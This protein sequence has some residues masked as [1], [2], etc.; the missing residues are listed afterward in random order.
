MKINIVIPMAGHGSRFVDAGYKE[1]KPLIEIKG[2]P[3]FYYSAKSLTNYFDYSKLIFI[4]LK[5][6]NKNNVLTNKIKNFFPNAIVKLLDK[7]PNGA[8]LTSREAVELIDNDYPVIFNDCDHIFYSEELVCNKNELKNFDGFILTFNSNLPIYSYC[9]KDKNG[10]VLATREKE[11]ISEDAIAGVYGFKNI[12]IFEEA[13]NEFLTNCEYG[14]FYTSGLYN[15]PV[16]DKGVIKSYK[17]NFNIS[18]GTPSEL[19][20]AKNNNIFYFY[21]NK[22]ILDKF[23]ILEDL[24]GMSEANTFLVKTKNNIFIRKIASNEASLKLKK[25]YRYII[26]NKYLPFPKILNKKEENNVFYYDMEYYSK[27]INFFTAINYFSVKKS[28]TIL[29]KILNDIN[30]SYINVD[31]DNKYYNNLFY[32]KYIKNNMDISLSNS[33]IKELS[34]YNSFFVNN[35][36][37][38]NILK[39][40]KELKKYNFSLN[41]DIKYIHGDLT[42]ENILVN[43]NQD[44]V[45]IDPS[46]MCNNIFCEYSKL[47]QSLHGKYEYLKNLITYEVEEN[48]IKYGNYSTKKYSELFDLTKQFIIDNYGYEGLKTIYFYEAVCH[49]RTLSYMVRLKKNN[50]VLMLAL[51]GLALKEWIKL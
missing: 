7:T 40:N 1:P 34:K 14:E 43:E 15:M 42:I 44:Y 24:S 5:E 47:F 25:Q 37:V 35:V 48:S 11:V 29:T 12:K 50:S 30:K 3:F 4:G 39:L 32:E 31:N 18:F 16:F 17:T 49:L 36:E 33:F 46:P 38:P 41:Y 9:L 21:D 2:F 26:E 6:H 8:V 22:I 45:I 28:W 27:M 20:K 13:S 19:L 10:N 51:S 23:S